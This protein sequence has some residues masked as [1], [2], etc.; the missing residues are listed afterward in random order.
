MTFDRLLAW[1]GL[2]CLLLVFGLGSFNTIPARSALCRLGMILLVIAGRT[3]TFGWLV[4][5]VPSMLLNRDTFTLSAPWDNL[6]QHAIVNLAR[7]LNRLVWPWMLFLGVIG[8]SAMLVAIVL[9][10]S[11]LQRM[12]RSLYRRSS[13][14]LVALLAVAFFAWHFYLDVGQT[15]YE[16]AYAAHRAAN[17]EQ[18]IDQYRRI[19]RFYPFAVV[20]Y[21]FDTRTHL[22]ECLAVREAQQAYQAQEVATAT[23]LYEA[24][25]ARN[26]VMAVQDLGRARL[27]EMRYAWASALWQDGEYER[28]LDRYHALQGRDVQQVLGESYLAWGESLQRRG[29]YQGAIATYRRLTFDVVNARLWDES[30]QGIQRAYCEWSAALRTA[31]DAQ[32]AAAVCTEFLD[33]FSPKVVRDCP[34]CAADE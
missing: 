16:R 19:E 31:G 1:A 8:L 26:P 2:G 5:A 4:S 32:R 12:V 25:L 9:R 34:A 30:E 14:V 13:R 20:G 6:A 22:V 10:L 17:L 23:L 27:L 3:L 29:D 11:R 7:A 24:V 18:A 21:V 33:A 28:A 15:L